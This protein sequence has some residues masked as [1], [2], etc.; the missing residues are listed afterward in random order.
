MHG[1]PLRFTS[2]ACRSLVQISLGIHIPLRMRSRASAISERAGGR[3]RARRLDRLCQGALHHHGRDDAFD[4]RRASPCRRLE[5]ARRLHRIRQA[6]PHAGFLSDLRTF[7]RARHRSRLAD[8]S[9]PQGRAFPILLPALDRDPDRFQI[10]AD[11]GSRR[12]RRRSH[13]LPAHRL[14]AAR[15]ALVSLYDRRFLRGG[16]AVSPSAARA[17]RHCAR[18]ACVV[19]AD[20]GDPRA[21]WARRGDAGR[22]RQSTGLFCDR[23]ARRAA[24]LPLCPMGRR[25]AGRRARRTFALG[26]GERHAGRDRLG[27]DAMGGVSARADGGRGRSSRSRGCSPR[28]DGSASC[29]M[30]ASTR[31]P[32]ILRSSCRWSSRGR[33]C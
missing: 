1:W 15:H 6:V 31:W 4:Q 24:G 26:D 19:A 23:L 3:E 28:A 9:R 10:R 29:A 17:F 5:L 16:E 22:I 30:P 21:T 12:T 20:R 14:G 2:K 33:F 8:L 32:S 18:L 27:R 11:P 25:M 7:P 13:R